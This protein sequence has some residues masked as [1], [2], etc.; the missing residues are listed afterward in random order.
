MVLTI[1]IGTTLPF[2]ASPLAADL[3][4]IVE[5][6]EAEGDGAAYAQSYGLFTCALAGGTLGGPVIAG[7][8]KEKFG[9][10]VM[11]WGLGALVASGAVPVVSLIASSKR[12][13]IDSNCFSTSIRAI[14]TLLI[15]KTKSTTIKREKEVMSLRYPA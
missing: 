10:N 8:L 6:L 11:T 9:W 13:V 15:T 4:Y 12:L 14:V 7:Y 5:I 1:Y 3:F 2:I